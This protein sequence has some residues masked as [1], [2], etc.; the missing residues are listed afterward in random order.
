[1][2]KSG[3][4]EILAGANL[5]FNYENRKQKAA[6]RRSTNINFEQIKKENVN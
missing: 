6:K 3:D 4:I 5:A 2:D 1:M